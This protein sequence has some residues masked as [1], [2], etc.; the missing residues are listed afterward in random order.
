MDKSP[1]SPAAVALRELLTEKRKSK[2]LHQNDVA[3]RLQRPQSFIS[4]YENGERKIDVID[5]IHICNSMDLNPT[6][7]LDEFIK[8]FN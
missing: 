4:K 7:V 6:E 1:H 5:F 2:G 8:R 3:A